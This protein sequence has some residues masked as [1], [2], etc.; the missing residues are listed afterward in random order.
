ML[1]PVQTQS[2]S[3]VFVGRD[4]ELTV[5]R[6]AL[7]R[8]G[9]GE[10]QALL[11]GGEAG[12]GKT[13]LLEEFLA[14]A[15]ASGAA[16]AVGG[17]VEIGADGLPYQPVSGALRMLHGALGDEL[18][19]A[20]AGFED[21][22]VRL[23][24]DLAEN[25]APAPRGPEYPDE[26]GRARLFELTARLLERISAE[27]TVVLAIEDLHWADRST[28]ELLAYLYRALHRAR[29]VVV[30]TYRTDD[31][32]RRHPLRPF[33]AELDRLRTVQRLELPRLSRDEVRRQMAGILHSEPDHALVERVFRRSDGNPFFVEELAC[34][35]HSGCATGLSDSL[36]DLLLV[37]VEALPE[38]AQRV[39]RVAA[40]GGSRVEHAL[41][42]AV[43]G[44]ADDDLD[45][46]LRAAV[47]ANILLLADGGDSYRFRHALVREAVVDDLLPGERSRVNRRYAQ[48]LEERPGLICASDRPA[49]L[50]SYWYH[51]GDARKALPAVLRASVEARRRHAHAEQLHLLQRAMELWDDV[52]DAERDQLP[53]AC[54]TE[55]YPPVTSGPDGDPAVSDARPHYLDLLAEAAVAARLSEQRERGLTLVKQ[56]LRL[57]D[58]DRD[59]VRAAWFWT[60]RSRL[61]KG[62]GRGDG[63]E[64]LARA[65]ELVCGVPPSAVHADILVQIA[66]WEMCHVPGERTLSTA[67]RAV[68]L[69]RLVGA[70]DVELNARVTLATL[71]V[72]SGEA[73]RG[74]AEL[75]ELARRA[76][77]RADTRALG[78]AHL[79]LTHVLEA[80]GRSAEAVAAAEEGL[81]AAGAAGVHNDAFLTANLAESLTS[82][83]EW[84]RAATLLGSAHD[85]VRHAGTRGFLTLRSAHLALLRGELDEAERLLGQ[86]RQSAARLGA[87][88]Q[89]LVPVAEAELGIAADRGR[90]DQARAVLRDALAVPPT[91]GHHAYWWQLLV[92]AAAAEGDAR[93][94]PGMD[95][96][97]DGI[98]ALLR[99]RGRALVTDA[100]VWVAWSRWFDAE[101][102][103]AD[104]RDDPA[105][106]AE[107]AAGFAPLHRPYALARV[108][109]RWAESLLAGGAPDR[110]R[111][112]A[113]LGEAHAT[114]GRLG[115]RLL[116][117]ETEL[118]ATRARLPL[119]GAPACPHH[120]ATRADDLGLTPRERDVLR[121][122]AA[123]RTNRA[124]AEE[125]FISPKT[126]SV[127]V[128]NILA[129]LGV[130]GRG[131]AAAVAHRLRL[132]GV[133]AAAG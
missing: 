46:A 31:I 7:D 55:A 50:A 107:A 108:G 127:H 39:V 122:V 112:A 67:E 33:L 86:V 75:R 90:Y 25:P 52:P 84:E 24:P 22:L 83:G 99:L 114:A 125:L 30:A 6:A 120:P 62:L 81:K 3:P 129:K 35:I 27:R 23:L 132:F 56:A 64:E 95:A 16:T 26:F 36:R 74:I 44:L 65:E 34:S 9:A 118:L 128:S 113:L 2:V 51:A 102:A 15:C 115:A 126:A 32:H 131:E 97:R 96:E 123:G 21:D 68:E 79:N 42:A 29:L 106:W 110:E 70:A 47:G 20:A 14:A 58:A 10:P 80:T 105:R 77:G 76:E 130:S 87:E 73:D 54:V 4:R 78:R 94:L 111:A 18:L 40:E 48:A 100:P 116:R 60:Q 92:R 5:L 59:P 82:L 103:R 43:A 12:V 66:G 45:E 49:R 109:Y 41:L 63:R 17:C 93:G 133:D 53:A 38:D 28:R 69:A 57:V 119:S 121:L 1:S 89:V 117:Q 71:R 13:R 11:V 104:G 91:L 19:R 61:V 98:L 124:I 101:L 88:P 85:N 37:R 72:A 8:A